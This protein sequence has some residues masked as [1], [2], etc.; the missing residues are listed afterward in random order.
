M[1][2]IVL[3]EVAYALASALDLVGIDDVQH[4]QRVALMASACARHGGWSESRCQ[5]LMLGGLLHD[6]GV[7]STQQHYRLVA[8]LD[9]E[10]SQEHADRG[11]E[12]LSR[13]PLFAHLEPLVRW[14]HTHWPQLLQAGLPQEQAL[15]ANLIYLVDRADVLRAKHFYQEGQ[16]GILRR[17]T[18]HS[19]SLFC[20]DL[21][22]LF[23]QVAT[24]DAFWFQLEPWVLEDRFQPWL[25]E[26]RH[27]LVS[28]D[29]L[30]SLGLMFADVVD[31]K[32]PYTASHSR[33]VA[34]LSL[35]LGERLA[36]SGRELEILE[37]AGLLH[38]LGKLRVEDDILAKPGPLSELEWRY[39]RQHSFDSAQ[40]LKRVGG[41]AEIATLAAMHHETLDGMGYPYRLKGAAIPLAAR[42]IAVADIF[43]ALVQDRPYRAAMAAGDAL[44]QLQQ[45]VKQG[46][47]D[48]RVVACLAQDLPLAVKIARQQPANGT[49][50]VL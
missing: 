34:A 15:A 35:W 2:E 31:A 27:Q 9:W 26:G 18:Q 42:I 29:S 13:V 23:E 10:G 48:R 36:L 21:L 11:A 33:G 47:L 28:F 38:D 50:R 16:E 43:Q 45:R 17:L 20:P 19:G 44:D 32:S 46:K 1:H 40:V 3:E 41:F 39:M 14:H 37:L 8:E 6:C 30:K 24:S 49:A 22:E 5:A 25:Q 4:G 12:L 7:S